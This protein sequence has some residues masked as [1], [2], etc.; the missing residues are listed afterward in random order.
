MRFIVPP[1][2]GVLLTVFIAIVW[3]PEPLVMNVLYI[4]IA[5]RLRGDD[6]MWRSQAV[7]GQAKDSR[8]EVFDSWRWLKKDVPRQAFALG[9]L[10]LQSGDHQQAIEQFQVARRDSRRMAEL[11]LGLAYYRTGQFE[12]LQSVWTDREISLLANRAEAAMRSDDYRAAQTLYEMLVV[13]R[14]QDLPLRRQLFGTQIVMQDWAAADKTLTTIA[15]LTR[16][17]ALLHLRLL[18]ASGKDQQALPYVAPAT[19]QCGQISG[20]LAEVYKQAAILTY[21]QGDGVRAIEWLKQADDASA[22]QDAMVGGLFADMYWG[23]GQ[24]DKA[25]AALLDFRRRFP[26]QPDFALRLGYTYLQLGQLDAAQTS[27]RDAFSLGRRKVSLYIQAASWLDELG[28]GE[29]ALELWREAQ[30]LDPGNA[31]VRQRL[32]KD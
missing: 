3:L 6:P 24:N 2:L 14:P 16:D 29:P 17:T 15:S 18:I 11:W 21:R 32:D 8:E 5:H 31:V 25:L 19:R 26:L 4:Q 22:G 20:C 13:A 7:K 10:A 30:S 27:F 9:Y 12:L 23:T 1:V 28:Y